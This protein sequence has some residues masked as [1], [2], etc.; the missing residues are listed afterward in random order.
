MLIFGQYR[1]LS[2]TVQLHTICGIKN[3]NTKKILD[4]K[5]T[6]LVYDYKTFLIANLFAKVSRKCQSWNGQP[7]RDMYPP[8]TDTSMKMCVCSLNT[9]ISK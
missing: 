2:H 5:Q 7:C 8:R 4:P 9:A 3:E 1:A 6:V